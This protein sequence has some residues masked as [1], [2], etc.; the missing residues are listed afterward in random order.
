[1]LQAVCVWPV[2]KPRYY[3]EMEQGQKAPGPSSRSKKGERAG[4]TPAGR[5][6]RRP[7]F[8]ANGSSAAVKR[9]LAAERAAR[10]SQ[11]RSKGHKVPAM[12]R[13]QLPARL[14]K[15][16][17][18]TRKDE[19]CLSYYDDDDND[20]KHC[21]QLARVLTAAEPKT[22]GCGASCDQLLHTA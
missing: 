2:P 4:T 17:Q 11:R 13:R 20:D 16:E 7:I 22:Q 18:K 8:V 19:V 9:P 5:A 12:S 21:E 3:D 1:M 14:D 15:P 6:T 10:C